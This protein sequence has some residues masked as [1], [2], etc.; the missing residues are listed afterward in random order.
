MD[1]RAL[2]TNFFAA[3]TSDSKVEELKELLKSMRGTKRQ[4]SSMLRAQTSGQLAGPGEHV[5]MKAGLIWRLSGSISLALEFVH[6]WKW[7]RRRRTVLHPMRVT[8]VDIR[9]QA[10]RDFDHPCVAAA[11]ATSLDHLWRMEVD[12]FLMETLLRDFVHTQSERGIS[13][14]LCALVEKLQSLWGHRPRPPKIQC[15]LHKLQNPTHAKKWFFRFRQRWQMGVQRPLN[16]TGISAETLQAKVR[17]VGNVIG[18]TCALVLSWLAYLP[19][20]P[21]HRMCES[22]PTPHRRHIVS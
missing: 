17:N 7:T 9:L 20:H 14:P 18:K 6:R 4:M 19:D 13:V 3:T 15:L 8:E 16:R 12:E 2:A 5:L 1:F 11:A 22:R 21:S 10:L